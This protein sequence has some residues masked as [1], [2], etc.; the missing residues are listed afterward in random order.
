MDLI[1]KVKNNIS[2]H[3]FPFI[4]VITLIA[5][6]FIGCYVTDHYVQLCVTKGDSMKPA[7]EN[8]QRFVIK[9]FDVK[10]KRYDI[11]T[12][13]NSNGERIVKRV[14]GLPNE[15]IQLVVGR[16]KISILIDGKEIEDKYTTAD[17]YAP[18]TAANPIKLGSDEY[19]VMGDN[20]LISCDSRFKEIGIITKNMIT[21]T[22][23][24]K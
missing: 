21:G 13:K 10:P 12:I 24:I 8:G 4:F 3:R 23:I 18:Y 11:V 22:C 6:I 1:K 15:T 2:N 5:T 7:L 14:Y 17:L 19:F 16:D 20:R 9:K